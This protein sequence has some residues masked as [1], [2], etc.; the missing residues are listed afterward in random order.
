MNGITA[1][2]LAT[3][4]DTR[5]VEAG[6][7]VYA[8]REGEYKSLSK[9]TKNENGD[10]VGYLEIPLAIGVL[11]GAINVNPTYRTALKIL[12][13]SNVEEFACVVAAVGLAQNV[14]ALRALVSEGIQKGHMTL[15]ARNI[16]I[17][18]GATGDQ[19]EIVAKTM[20]KEDNISFDR[21]KEL[22]ND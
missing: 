9:F 22:L 20:I 16:A 2:L 14:A 15:H 12:S 21:A 7:H 3:G 11:G 17:N 18:A 19:I 5:A 4:N 13:V 6:A 10:L 8:T 1:V